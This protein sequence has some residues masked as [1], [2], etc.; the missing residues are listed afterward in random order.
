MMMQ[1]MSQ[2]ARQEAINAVLEGGRMPSEVARELGV[3]GKTLLRWIKEERQ[4]MAKRASRLEQEARSMEV[5]LA[6]LRQEISA[7]KDQP[8][9]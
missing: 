8:L 4:P 6:E 2:Q 5:R 3:A 7:M 1:A 9:R